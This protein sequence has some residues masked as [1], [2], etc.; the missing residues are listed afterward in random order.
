MN[1]F[2][3]L[4]KGSKKNDDTDHIA[5]ML[6][7]NSCQPLG[8]HTKDEVLLFVTQFLSYVRKHLMAG[9]Q[10]DPEVSLYQRFG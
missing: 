10:K 7:C 4:K 9:K 1:A 2:Q 3:A 6:I 5:S 8:V